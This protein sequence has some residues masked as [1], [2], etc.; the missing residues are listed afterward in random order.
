LS[1]VSIQGGDE[2]RVNENIEWEQEA[3]DD[4]NGE[5]D[6]L[7]SYSANING[8]HFATSAPISNHNVSFLLSLHLL[9]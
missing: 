6:H 7:E 1:T 8:D 4:D 9:K 3:F 5:R 2:N